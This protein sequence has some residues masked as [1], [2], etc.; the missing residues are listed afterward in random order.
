[1]GLTRVYTVEDMSSQVIT[2]KV[3]PTT[4]KEAHHVAEEL[5][6]PLIVVI[7]AFL[8]QFIRTKIV[9][10]SAIN[11]KPS[12]YLI[13]MVKQAREDLKGGKASPTFKTGEKAVTWLEKH[14]I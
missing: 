12:Q 14:D 8:K 6:M 7:K 11:E 5:G 10:F 9:T 4:K 2:I 1:M 3:D 13:Y